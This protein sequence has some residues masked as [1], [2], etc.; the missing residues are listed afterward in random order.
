MIIHIMLVTSKASLP[1]LF[2][3]ALKT[4]VLHAC[5]VQAASQGLSGNSATAHALMNGQ[6]RGAAALATQRQHSL[7]GPMPDSALFGLGL[8]VGSTL[9]PAERSAS[10]SLGPLPPGLPG[11]SAFARA[12]SQ[13]VYSSPF[14]GGFGGLGSGPHPLSG[15]LPDSAGFGAVGGPLSAGMASD[16]HRRSM[17][18][19]M[20]ARQ[21]TGHL[22]PQQDAVL[23]AATSQSLSGLQGSLPLNARTDLQAMVTG[24]LG[25]EGLQGLSLDTARSAGLM[26]RA[27]SAGP[28]LSHGLGGPGI[29]GFTLMDRSASGGLGERSG[30]G[31]LAQQGS[32]P[33]PMAGL[34]GGPTGH[35]RP[36]R[37]GLTTQ[38]FDAAP[39]PGSAPLGTAGSG[40]LSGVPL[41][42]SA[43]GSAVPSPPPAASAAPVTSLATPATVPAGMSAAALQKVV[44]A[45]NQGNVYESLGRPPAIREDQQLEGDFGMLPPLS[46]GI[47][48]R[49]P[50]YIGRNASFDSILAEL[51][52]SLS[53]VAMNKGQVNN[54]P[55]ASSAA[56]PA[57]ISDATN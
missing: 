41:Y 49:P 6:A 10:G 50:S 44:E 52:R 9:A 30:S 31:W 51:P 4:N 11:S 26:E 23:G 43:P 5:I 55:V 1:I 47:G 29:G 18:M 35:V 8:G 19:S 28:G 21:G 45:A 2:K 42:G 16:Q 14:G 13:P 32:A 53:E 15:R 37:L 25:L 36:S 27:A 17:D 56:V 33:S 24:N 54:A 34:P 7:D 12:G 38:A 3:P 48:D 40:F 20:L 46:S 22:S 39:V 57:R